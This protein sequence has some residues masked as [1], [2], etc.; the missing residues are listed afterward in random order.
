MYLKLLGFVLWS[1]QNGSLFW[2]WWRTLLDCWASL[3]GL[4]MLT[5]CWPGHTITSISRICHKDDCLQVSLTSQMLHQMGVRTQNGNTNDET[6]KTSLTNTFVLVVEVAFGIYTPGLENQYPTSD[7]IVTGRPSSAAIIRAG[8]KITKQINTNTFHKIY[9]YFKRYTNIWLVF[10][11]LVGYLS[12]RP[13][14]G[15][16]VKQ[17]KW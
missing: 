16:M 7:T 4:F 3:N 5:S 15:P 8:Q 9:E 17:Y 6:R 1:F 13:H 12:A 11:L 10:P 2:K 14:S